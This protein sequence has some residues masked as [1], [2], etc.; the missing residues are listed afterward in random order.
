M[1][2]GQRAEEAARYGFTDI[3][4]L[5]ESKLPTTLISTLDIYGTGLHQV[6][7]LIRENVRETK[8]PPLKSRTI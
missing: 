6:R 2:I 7:K 5:N 1:R 8:N 3:A 4:D